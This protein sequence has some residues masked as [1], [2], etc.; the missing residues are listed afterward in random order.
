MP[1]SRARR[2]RLDG[3]SPEVDKAAAEAA[4]ALLRGATAPSEVS[5]LV[6]LR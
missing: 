4:A 1:G 5:D 6:P 2:D 3:V